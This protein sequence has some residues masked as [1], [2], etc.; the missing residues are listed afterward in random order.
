MDL[1]KQKEK[2]HRIW[3]KSVYNQ[4]VQNLNILIRNQK[5]CIFDNF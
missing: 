5:E 4:A 3:A 2:L 1:Q